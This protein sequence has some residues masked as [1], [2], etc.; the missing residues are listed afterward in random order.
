MH[1][2]NLLMI[3]ISIVIVAV[4]ITLFIWES[5][6]IPL[7]YNKNFSRNTDT[8]EEQATLNTVE[9]MNYSSIISKE[10]FIGSTDQDQYLNPKT[11]L[12]YTSANFI[13]S[14]VLNYYEN[15]FNNLHGKGKPEQIEL[16]YV[17]NVSKRSEFRVFNSPAPQRVSWHNTTIVI[18]APD[19]SLI[20]K[21][22]GHMQFYYRN[23]SGY[24][25]IEWDFDFNFSDCQVIEMKLLYSEIYASTA[26]FFVDI[27]QIVV[28][29]KYLVPL[30]I[31]VKSGMVVA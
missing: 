20:R 18:S 27:E 11:Y 21:D 2:R 4:I 9:S 17:A 29:D 19:G 10:R 31:G 30:L 15:R 22:N 12:A 28:I 3:T 13:D 16:T 26:A 5:G 23:N 7:K 8:Q 25:M 6:K 24:Q 1:R 14:E